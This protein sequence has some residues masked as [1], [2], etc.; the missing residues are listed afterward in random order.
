M[1][2]M[3]GIVQRFEMLTLQVNIMAYSQYCH[4]L[5]NSRL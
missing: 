1:Q 5:T 4:D 3:G 2:S